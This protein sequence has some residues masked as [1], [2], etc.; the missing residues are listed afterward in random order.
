MTKNKIIKLLL[1]NSSIAI[2]GLVTGVLVA[3]SLSVIDRGVLGEIILW[4]SL[5]FSVGNGVIKD[6][7]YSRD[8]NG[9]VYLLEIII[10]LI[11]MCLFSI[12]LYLNNLDEYFWFFWALA[13]LN[14]FNM[15]YISKLTVLGEVGK[16]SLYK[17]IT[18]VVYL[19]ILVFCIIY[20]QLSIDYI[21]ST[22][23]VSNGVLLVLLIIKEKFSLVYGQV[24]WRKLMVISLSILIIAVNQQIDKV[25]IST[26]FKEEFLANYLI[27]LTICITPLTIL[28]QSM[29]TIIVSGV[30]SAKHKL[31]YFD[32]VC[33]VLFF[34]FILAALALYYIA[35]LLLPL[36]FG[37]KYTGAIAYIPI[38]LLFS[39]IIT[40]R[41][42]FFTMLRALSLDSNILIYQISTFIAGVLTLLSVS[43]L[44]LPPI[45][46]LWLFGLIFFSIFI[47]ILACGRWKVKTLGENN[48]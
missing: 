15:V 14:L 44:V 9:G 47:V 13:P 35:P 37:N 39:V 21:L 41:A 48:A 29:T 32:K 12:T 20:S 18:P 7:I 8:S 33:S 45:S 36:V 27:A 40:Y 16:I 34:T 22:M 42:V 3:R 28:S 19:L 25:I 5:A 38:A 17:L 46:I 31:S 4:S 1:S 23:I 24:D 2:I 11:I 26:L 10:M 30:K 43:Y 6:L